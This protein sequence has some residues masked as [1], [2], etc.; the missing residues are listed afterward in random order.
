MLSQSTVDEREPGGRVAAIG[1]FISGAVTKKQGPSV[2]HR[3]NLWMEKSVGVQLKGTPK[4]LDRLLV[5]QQGNCFP[6]LGLSGQSLHIGLHWR[7]QFLLHVHTEQ[8]SILSWSLPEAGSGFCLPIHIPFH[9]PC[10]HR[11]EK[12]RFLELHCQSFIWALTVP[13]TFICSFTTFHSFICS[14]IQ[15][16]LHQT[17]TN[18]FSMSLV[19]LRRI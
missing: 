3:A 7:T 12:P 10:A 5:Y 14:F 13:H 17:N 4:F 16:S 6:G 2:G 8:H 15:S 11:V 18:L 1:S 9:M 19:C